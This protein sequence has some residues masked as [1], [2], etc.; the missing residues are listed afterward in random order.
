MESKKEDHREEVPS[1]QKNDHITDYDESVALVPARAEP[2]GNPTQSLIPKLDPY[3][4]AEIMT[5]ITRSYQIHQF[6]WTPTDN[7]GADLYTGEFPQDLFTVPFLADKLKYYSLFRSGVKIT[8][9]FN[10]TKFQYGA[11]I[12]SWVPFYDVTS[13]TPLSAAD[14]F[15]DIYA[16]SQCNSVLISAQQGQSV[17]IVI[18]WVNPHQWGSLEAVLSIIGTLKIKVLHP[19]T[20]VGANGPGYVYVSVFANFHNPEIA[21]FSP[22]ISP[23]SAVT[24]RQARAKLRSQREAAQAQSGSLQKHTAISKSEGGKPVS[25]EAEQKS[26]QGIIS[27]SITEATKTIAPIIGSLLPEAA[28]VVEAVGG[29]ASMLSPIFSLLGLSKPTSEAAFV[30]MLQR[31]EPGLIHGRGLDEPIRLSLDPKNMIATTPG[32]LGDHNPQPSLLSIMMK[33]SLVLNTSFTSATTTDNLLFELFCAPMG[34]KVA[35]NVNGSGEDQWQLSYAAYYSQFAKYWRGSV[36]FQLRFVTSSFIT[37][38][39]RISHVNEALSSAISVVSGDLVSR[40]VDIVGDTTVEVLVPYLTYEYYVPC[41]HPSDY[42]PFDDVGQLQVHLVNPVTTSDDSVSPTIYCSVWQSVGPDFRL[43][44]YRDQLRPETNLYKRPAVVP[45][46]SKARVKTTT[47][48]FI[49]QCDMISEFKTKKFHGLQPAS[50]MPEAALVNGE[51][52]G[53]LQNLL[54]RY[55][56]KTT[57]TSPPISGVSF[58]ILPVW[59]DNIRVDQ[60]AALVAPFQ[61]MRGA[62]RMYVVPEIDTVF[63]PGDTPYSL[64]TNSPL[65]AGVAFFGSNSCIHAEVPWYDFRAFIETNPVMDASRF[66]N[67]LFDSSVVDPTVIYAVGDDFSVGSLLC[68]PA[69][70]IIPPGPVVSKV[71][72]HFRASRIL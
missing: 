61:F 12:A 63:L 35:S 29:I 2:A 18:P 60:H 8:L 16:M 24:I 45:P 69:Q 36:R 21:G 59:D 15:R 33:P 4:S 25:K 41:R 3:P 14:K 64:G 43:M 40:V 38:R 68:V 17:E 19:L 1:I 20:S 47:A 30:K 42:V 62:G 13:V 55:G 9:R 46:K 57:S 27:G 56:L 10:T 32:I 6:Q 72:R 39:V 66:D 26:S 44:G 52:F 65:E 70:Y 51:D 34:A 37:A 23:P 58:P 48:E 31:V 50:Y 11:L 67:V 28:P 53:T 54:H 5:A 49:T 7:E 22:D 71:D